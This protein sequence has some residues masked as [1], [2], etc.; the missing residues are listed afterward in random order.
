MGLGIG[1]VLV[2]LYA[3]RL[4]DRIPLDVVGQPSRTGPVQSQLEQ[5]F[6][7]HLAR[8]TGLPLDVR[9]RT[10]D[11]LGFKDNYQLELLRNGSLDLV[12]LRFLQNATTEPT[13]LGIDLLGLTADFAT[14]RAVVKAYAPVLDQRLQ[15]HFDSKLLGIWPF[16]PQVF[17]CRRAIR[18]LDDISGRKIRVGSENF[19]PLIRA[20]G[21]TPVVI[22]FDDVQPAL[23]SGLIDCAISS[24][25]SGHHAG[26]PRHS[27]HLFALGTQMGL[28]GYVVS[29]RVWDRLSR[30]QQRALAQAFEHHVNAIWTFAR[31]A[32]EDSIDCIVGRACPHGEAHGLTE[33]RPSA[34][35]H[36]RLRDLFEQTTFKDWSERCNRVHPGCADDWRTRVRPVLDQHSALPPANK[37]ALP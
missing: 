3:W 20:L 6:F 5:P 13:L 22:P 30:T 32:H 8:T 10:I 2:F 14:A 4:L 25:T 27:T 37:G 36:Q 31:Q 1:L 34:Q 11:T 21:G 12:S 35:D 23:E 28:N 24:A 19:A 9:Y 26:W 29:L 16:G 33:V 15:T 17:F 7:D 18:G